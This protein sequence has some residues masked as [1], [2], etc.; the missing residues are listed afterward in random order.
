LFVQGSFF[1]NRFSHFRCNQLNHGLT[2]LLALLTALFLPAVSQAQPLVKDGQTIA[3][4][5]DSITWAGNDTPVGY[6][7]LVTSGLA[8]NGIK[9]TP[10]PSG[11]PGQTSRDMLRRLDQDI[12]SKKPDWM[13][14]SCG[15][16]DVWHG[17]KGVPL[18]E[19]KRNITQLVEQAQTAGV[20][21]LLLTSTM[22][23]ENPADPFNKK[24][25]DYNDFLRALAREK[26]CPLADLNA[27]MQA[28][29]AQ[30]AHDVG[31]SPPPGLFLTLDGVHMNA[32]GNE[33]MA[34][35]ILRALGLSDAQVKIAQDSWQDVPQSSSTYSQ[36]MISLRQFKQLNAIA[37][38][39]HLSVQ[40]F[41]DRLYSDAL[42]GALRKSP[43]KHQR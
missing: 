23:T 7:R 42:D 9:I 18:D 4:M 12:L 28:R 31:V 24:L 29:V 13:T 8:S 3:F 30:D 40:G 17:D 21:V 41:I 34:L 19:Y 38:A 27:D 22:I 20:K 43:V 16:N 37:F 6:V 15:V 39:Q 5:G 1:M 36:R 33:V 26:Q 11:I 10:I 2:L 32:L 14:L 35:G 25:A